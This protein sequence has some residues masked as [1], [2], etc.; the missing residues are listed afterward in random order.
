MEQAKFGPGNLIHVFLLLDKTH[1]RAALCR[2]SGLGE[3]SVRTILRVL[4]RGGLATGTRKGH[5]LT[6][7]GKALYDYIGSIL[8]ISENCNKFPGKKALCFQIHPP[9]REVESYKLR[10]LAVAEGA[11]GAMIFL[12][13]EL[14]LVLPPSK[15]PEH[16]E[17]FSLQGL[18]VGD[19]AA[20]VWGEDLKSVAAGGIGIAERVSPRLSEVFEHEFKALL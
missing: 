15:H 19:C 20:I 17:E 11:E 4:K 8:K 1:S 5:S 6:H 9:L 13:T 18:K 7:K 3:G 12:C 10:D 14:G 16:K 2:A